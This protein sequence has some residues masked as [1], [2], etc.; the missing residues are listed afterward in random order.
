MLTVI[1]QAEDG[2]FGWY[3]GFAIAAA[4]IVVVVIIV[5][6]ILRL[7]ERIGKQARTA[8]DVIDRGRINTLPLWDVHWTNQAA[9]GILNDMQALGDV[10]EESRR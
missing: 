3:L 6:A 2:L 10:L 9:E 8:V 1:A 5:A 7:A 4:I